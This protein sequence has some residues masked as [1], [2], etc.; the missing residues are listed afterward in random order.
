MSSLL[1]GDFSVADAFYAPVCMR[2]LT[3]DLPLPADIAAYVARVRQLPGVRAWADDALAECDFRD[4]EEPYR[5][6]R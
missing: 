2:L 5:K 4:F 1:F 6:A 3:Y